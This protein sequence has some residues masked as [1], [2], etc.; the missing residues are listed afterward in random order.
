MEF[1]MKKY[2]LL[3]FL[4]LNLSPLLAKTIKTP[5]TTPY[6]FSIVT[7][8]GGVSSIGGGAPKHSSPTV[9]VNLEWAIPVGVKNFY[10]YTQFRNSFFIGKSLDP[11]SSLLP[12]IHM[13]NFKMG[14]LL[15]FGGV[16][17]DWRNPENKGSYITF[18]SGFVFEGSYHNGHLKSKFIPIESNLLENFYNIGIEI[19]SRYH[20]SFGKYRDI[21]LGFTMGYL[22]SPISGDPF[23]L[24]L[25]KN[26]VS[27]HMLNYGVSFGYHF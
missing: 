5:A 18:N 17:G 11:F 10:I 14:F 23:Y 19:N 4:L 6:Y 9:W 8:I 20:Y 25:Q 2:I 3:L 13:E 21:S 7:T 16:V 24:G 15:G 27:F 1:F 26:I 22:Y 12:V